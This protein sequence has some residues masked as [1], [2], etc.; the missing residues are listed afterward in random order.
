MDSLPSKV[1]E[2][3]AKIKSVEHRVKDLE[4]EVHDLRELTKA[5]A[6]TNSNVKQL[7]NQFDESVEFVQSI[8]DEYMGS[9]LTNPVFDEDTYVKRVKA[10]HMICES[11]ETGNACKVLMD[12]IKE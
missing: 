8:F 2:H 11:Y 12:L 4:N 10:H 6:V 3:D 1:M 7:S 9:D 5:V